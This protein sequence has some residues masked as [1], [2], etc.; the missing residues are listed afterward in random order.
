MPISP[1]TKPGTHVVCVQQPVAIFGSLTRHL[2]VGAVYRL[3]RIIML[4]NTPMVVLV[5]FPVYAFTLD[6]FEPAVLPS[7]LTDALTSA[8]VD[9]ALDDLE[10]V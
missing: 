1:H 10:M 3:K 9:P 7:C 5:E 2:T 4:F 6:L 8:P